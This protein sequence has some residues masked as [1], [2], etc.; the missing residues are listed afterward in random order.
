MAISCNKSSEFVGV[1]SILKLF[2]PADSRFA[3]VKFT[4]VSY[5][6]LGALYAKLR[7]YFASS[8]SFRDNSVVRNICLSL[9]R[10]SRWTYNYC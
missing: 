2:W 8:K 4:F 7:L 5:V 10:L 9:T 1:Y 6:A 3:K